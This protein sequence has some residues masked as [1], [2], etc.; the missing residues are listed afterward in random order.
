MQPGYLAYASNGVLF[1]QWTRTGNT[2]TGTLSES[3]TDLSNPAQVSHESHT[4]TG[5]I[6]GSS[7]TITLDTGDNWNGTITGSSVTLNTPPGSDGR[8]S[9][10]D[11]R[12][13]TVAD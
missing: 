7:I 5:V 4:F 10:F 9:S 2:V 3:Y 1:F 13:A 11:F 12:P 6:N 8:I